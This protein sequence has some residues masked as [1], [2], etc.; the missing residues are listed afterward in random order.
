MKK[1][2]V[3]LLLLSSPAVADN[4]FRTNGTT[5][6][7]TTGTTDTFMSDGNP[8]TCCAW[9]YPITQGEGN[10]GR[11]CDRGA[12]ATLGVGFGMA[13]T[14]TFGILKTGSSDMTRLASNSS[15]TLNAWQYVCGTSDG[16]ITAANHH[17]YKFNEK[18]VGG[19]VTYKTTTNGATEAN[20]SA[21]AFRIGNNSGGSRTFNG[22]INHVQ[23]WNYVL[24]IPQMKESAIHPGDVGNPIG[25][26][27]DKGTA[28]GAV[29]NTA[30][31]GINDSTAVTAMTESTTSTKGV[32]GKVQLN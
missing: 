4:G 11:I 21:V 31:P 13:A 7:I 3:I 22:M 12:S 23:V 1:L 14:N 8:W 25:Y 9:I 26:Y 5:S 24:T 10:A 20:N 17:I 28:G 30:H 18:L 32:A 29:K 2:I 27:Y 19:E 15:A 6:V 16:S